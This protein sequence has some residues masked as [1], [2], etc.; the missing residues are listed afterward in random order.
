MKK[1]DAIKLAGSAIK[2]AKI[3]GITKGAISHWGDDVPVGR[4]YQLRYIKPEWFK[5][6]K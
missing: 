1:Q 4:V 3:L 2:L 5:G 6:Q